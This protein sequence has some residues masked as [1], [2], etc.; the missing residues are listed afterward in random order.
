M[1]QFTVPQFID[2]EDKIIGPITT[3]Q[4]I[5]MLVGGLLI[6][7]F[8]KILAFAYFVLFSGL[9]FIF[10]ITLAFIRINGQPFHFF[11]LNILQTWR[12]PNLQIWDKAIPDAVLKGLLKVP[13]APALKV[14]PRKEA[15]TAS[16]LAEI[17]LQVDTGGIYNAE[18]L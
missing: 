15:P 9:V 12:S 17:A 16:R 11:L 5:I 13:P 10:A 2:V 1:H 14:K 18:E 3:R 4:F 8:Y 6:F 7:T